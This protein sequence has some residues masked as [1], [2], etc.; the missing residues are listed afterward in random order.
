MYEH[1]VETKPYLR[2]FPFSHGFK[3]PIAYRFFFNLINEQEFCDKFR[4]NRT[5]IDLL[6]DS[7]LCVFNFNNYKFYIQHKNIEKH[8]FLSTYDIRISRESKIFVLFCFILFC[9][10][11]DNFSL[12]IPG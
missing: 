10:V 8:T 3:W 11:Q 1:S 2:K 5:V 9:F 6:E 7:F 12:F 4:S